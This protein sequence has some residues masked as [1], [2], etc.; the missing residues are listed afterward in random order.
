[1]FHGILEG[2]EER[3]MDDMSNVSTAPI[4]GIGTEVVH[5]QAPPGGGERSGPE[6][7]G[8]ELEVEMVEIK[9]IRAN[10]QAPDPEVSEKAKR[11]RYS[12][13][14]K[15]KILK[16]ADACN[17]DGEIGAL[18]RREGLYS[19]ALSRWRIDHCMITTVTPIY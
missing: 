19:A 17:K 15:L 13:D 6:P 5:P 1:M 8:R 11:R 7:G 18:L 9:P 4:V 10:L 2:V 14:Y 12:A 3:K 16:E